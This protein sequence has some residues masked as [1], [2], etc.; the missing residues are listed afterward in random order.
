[1]ILSVLFEN[2]R[3]FTN[4]RFLYSM[5]IS[6]MDNWVCTVIQN[7]RTQMQELHKRDQFQN[8]LPLLG[9]TLMFCITNMETLE[10]VN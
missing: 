2:A 4:K 1:M 9:Y 3:Q 7:A 5:S 8:S 10:N 6:E